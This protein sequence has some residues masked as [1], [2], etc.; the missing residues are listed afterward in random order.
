VALWECLGTD[1]NVSH[2]ISY[3]RLMFDSHR[4]VHRCCLEAVEVDGP[5][6]MLFSHST[7]EY[8]RRPDKA[9]GEWYS[10]T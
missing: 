8:N 1:T 9:H 4:S 10:D 2:P 6:S 5:R 7:S 3:T